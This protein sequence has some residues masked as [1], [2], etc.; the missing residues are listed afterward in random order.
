MRTITIGKE[1]VKLRFLAILLIADLNSSLLSDSVIAF[2]EQSSQQ[3]VI[4][5]IRASG[6]KVGFQSFWLTRYGHSSLIWA[7][8][9]RSS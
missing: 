2:L 4:A 5:L 7:V 9:H 3:H 8:S 6:M 1:L